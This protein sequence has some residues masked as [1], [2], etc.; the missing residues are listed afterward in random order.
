V[1]VA[2]GELGTPSRG[3]IHVTAAQRNV[4]SNPSLKAHLSDVAGRKR[5]GLVCSS[6]SDSQ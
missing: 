1:S 4:H 5:I 6:V 3:H 2:V